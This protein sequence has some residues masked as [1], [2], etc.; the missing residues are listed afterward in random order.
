MHFH[1]LAVAGV[2]AAVLLAA[3]VTGLGT[4]A[5]VRADS[6]CQSEY[7]YLDSEEA[8]FVGLLNRH[9]AAHG[10]RPSAR[11]TTWSRSRPGWPAT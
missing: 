9:R 7:A 2:A 8:A 3:T 1:R 10:L 11:G 6:L 4:G 5:N